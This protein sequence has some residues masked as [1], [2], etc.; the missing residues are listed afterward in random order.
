MKALTG[1]RSIV[2][3]TWALGGWLAPR[4]GRFTRGK[5]VRYPLYRRLCG[6]QVRSGQVQKI[7]FPSEPDPRTVQLVPSRNTD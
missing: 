5:E 7:S 4:P 1:S 2:L 3:L 6:S